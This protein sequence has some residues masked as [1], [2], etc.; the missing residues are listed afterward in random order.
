MKK[1]VLFV[2]L[3]GAT[4][5]NVKLNANS[6]SFGVD[7]SFE[8]IKENYTKL[9][10]WGLHTTVDLKNCDPD[11]IRSADAIREFCIQL[12]NLIKMKRFG[13]PHIVHFGESEIVAGYTLVQLIETSDITAHFANATNNAYIDIF[14]CKL[15][16]PQLVIVFAKEFFKAEDVVVHIILRI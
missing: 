11:L 10:A 12:C 16:D 14:S 8:V 9:N 4:V 7:T 2:L 5:G 3:A 1:L 15:Y 13:E 6:S